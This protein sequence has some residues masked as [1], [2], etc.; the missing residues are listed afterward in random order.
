MGCHFN[1]KQFANEL[2]ASMFELSTME[3]MQK[4]YVHAITPIKNFEYV[5]NCTASLLLKLEPRRAEW[6]RGRRLCASFGKYSYV[7]WFEL[8]TESL[9]YMPERLHHIFFIYDILLLSKPSMLSLKIVALLAYISIVYMKIKSSCVFL[10]NFM[11]YERPVQPNVLSTQRSFVKRERVWLNKTNYKN[12]D[13][14]I[15]IIKYK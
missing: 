7:E 12:L 8:R 10:Q 2:I 3:F 13:L 5:Y 1:G 6:F 4:T 11:Y 9:L 14:S 15:I